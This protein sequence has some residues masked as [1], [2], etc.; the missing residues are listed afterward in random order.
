MELI[1]KVNVQTIE[2]KETKAKFN[3]YNTFIKN[4]G[5]EKWTKFNVKFKKEVKAPEKTSYVYADEK[6]ISI[7]EMGKYPT[8]F[9]SKVS[10]VQ[11]I[12]F[13]KANLSKYFKQ[14]PLTDKEVEDIIGDPFADKE[15]IDPKD[16]PF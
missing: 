13:D 14:A 1:I 8:I 15:P 7:N 10:K 9:I 16:L 6:D 5:D 3:V 2:N 12:N 4:E 11:P